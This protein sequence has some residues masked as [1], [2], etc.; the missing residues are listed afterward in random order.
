LHLTYLATRLREGRGQVGLIK[1]NTVAEWNIFADPHAAKEVFQTGIPIYLIA[2]DAT[3]NIP[4]T[5][6]FY[7]YVENTHKTPSAAL[8]YYLLT[9]VKPCIQSDG[10]YFWDLVAAE[11][12]LYPDLVYFEPR[13]IDVITAEGPR[14]GQTVLCDTGY[15]IQL[16]TKI[17]SKNFLQVYFDS[18]NSE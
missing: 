16:A 17:N 2:L 1:D 14:C 12:L 8:F 13:M 7:E 9:G 3:K 4:L 5:M 6:D 15:F 11:T 10:F 18:I